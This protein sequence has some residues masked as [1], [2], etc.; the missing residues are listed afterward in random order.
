MN[1]GTIGAKLFRIFVKAD[2]EG[3]DEESRKEY[4]AE[5]IV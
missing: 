5:R 2:R 1:R 4:L 3:L